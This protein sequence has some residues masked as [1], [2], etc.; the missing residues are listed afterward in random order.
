M[1]KTISKN[2][3]R[4]KKGGKKVSL[5]KIVN[6]KLRN[7]TLQ[8]V[9]FTRESDKRVIR[10]PITDSFVRTS[11][12]RFRPGQEIVNDLRAIQHDMNA[13]SFRV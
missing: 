1:T 8:T 4:G 5:S 3:Y 13:D 12:G 9:T 2:P 6:I 7:G 10:Q 11:T